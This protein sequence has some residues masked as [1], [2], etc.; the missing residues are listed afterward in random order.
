VCAQMFVSA[1]GDSWQDLARSVFNDPAT[2]T[3]LASLFFCMF[4]LVVCWIMF[5][6]VLFILLDEF[7]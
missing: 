5:N 3:F 6:I 2:P 4:V 1:T 7:G